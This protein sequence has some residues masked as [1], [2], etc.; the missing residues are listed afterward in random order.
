MLKN[1]IINVSL[2]QSILALILIIVLLPLLILISLI[3]FLDTRKNPIFI[4]ERGL[5]L[6]KYRFK[7]IKFRTIKKD[8]P[9]TK[10]INNPQ[11]LKKT[12][13]WDDISIVGKFLRKTG[14]DE[15]PQ[16]FNVLLGHMNFI[17]PRALSIE[18]LN[19]IKKEYPDFY[20]R[21]NKLNSK[22][23]ILGLWQV[24]KDLECSIS[25]LI[26]LDEKY[27]KAKSIWMDLRIL[28]RAFEI[29]LFGYHIDSIVNGK[30]LKIYPIVVYTTFISTIL[31]IIFSLINFK[32]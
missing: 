5:T 29:I 20:E 7:L 10:K 3:S 24:N 22:P 25:H 2:F 6:E 26:E 8:Y 19:R 1:S 32:F 17:G 14:L 23:G 30:N 4:Q 28:F 9:E 11:I 18:D 13:L 21:R 12:F 31:L 15:L 27:E 16:V